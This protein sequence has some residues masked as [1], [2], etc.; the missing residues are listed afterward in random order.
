MLV[1]YLLSM[2]HLLRS[3]HHLAHYTP[4]YDCGKIGPTLFLMMYDRRGYFVLLKSV[5]CRFESTVTETTLDESVLGWDQSEASKNLGN[6][7][8]VICSDY[9]L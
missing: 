6:L 1:V 4:F 7:K 9:L 2:L 8:T 3:W 5:F